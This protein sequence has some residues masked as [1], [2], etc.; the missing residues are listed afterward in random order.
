L[1]VTDRY[2]VIG[3]P[4]GH[5]KSPWIHAKFAGQTREDIEYGSILAPNEGFAAVVAAFRGNGGKGANVTLPFKEEAYAISNELSERALAARAVNTLLFSK[6]GISGD[7]TDGCGL[8]RDLKLNQ[9]FEIEGRRVLLLGAGGAARGVLL[10]LLEE[11]PASLVVANRNVEKARE[12]VRFLPGRRGEAVAVCSYDSLSGAGFDLVINATSAGLTDSAL[13]L[14]AGLFAP[15]S[16]AYEMMY[17]RE[18]AFMRQAGG[19]GAARISDGLGMLVEQAAESFFLW[20][21]V[22]PRTAPVLAELRNA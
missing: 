7:N 5:S 22:R 13:P 6:S 11:R 3:N 15:G 9:A 19:D 4:V 8:T 1:R 21:G 16:L 14:P 12:L 2:A 20:R 10:P 17:G 18:T